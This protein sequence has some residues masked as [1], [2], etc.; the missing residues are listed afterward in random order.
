[1]SVSQLSALA[2]ARKEAEQATGEAGKYIFPED[3]EHDM[4][5]YRLKTREI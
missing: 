1:M 2:K 4:E 3:G 5:A